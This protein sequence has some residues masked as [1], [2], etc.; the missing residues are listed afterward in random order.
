MIANGPDSL[1][2]AHAHE[3][4]IGGRWTRP[5]SDARLSLVNPAEGGTFGEVAEA[6][7]ADVAAAVKAARQAFDFGPWP[8]L[9]VSERASMLRAVSAALKRR[10]FAAAAA[11]TS[12]I[13]VPFWMSELIG[14]QII[15]T[16]DYY[17]DLIE[18]EPL[19]DTRASVAPGSSIALVVKEPVG[20]VAAIA[21]W[22]AP[23]AQM[24]LK[25]APALAAGCTVVAKPAPESPI[26]AFLLA[27][28][29]EEA[30]L[31]AGVFN[32]LPAGRE[33][34]DLLVRHEGI[35]KVS[36][37]G[38]TAVGTHIAQICAGRMARVTMEL[39]GKSA[40]VVLE[41]MDPAAAAAILAPVVTTMS[42]QVCSN[43]TRILT[44]RHRQ[45]AY[46]EALSAAMAATS[47]GDPHEPGVMMGP[48]A[49]Q[50]QRERVEGYISIGVAEGARLATGGGR[51]RGL[52][53]GFFFEPTVFDG[54]TND[55]VIAREEIF[56]PVAVIIPYDN[57]EDA[58]RLANASSFGLAGA[59]LTKDT[60][61]AYAIARRMRTGSI[62]QNGRAIDILIPFG[63]FKRSGMGRECG[64]EGLN[65][66]FELKSIFLPA[67]P[68]EI[69]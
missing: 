27:E 22:N 11:W 60:D 42:G 48:L 28:A 38:S 29:I 1:G 59:V 16:L 43:L 55:M 53:R 50:R 10:A 20:V 39:G 21:P 9:P 47:V 4:F 45:K 17:A 69:A 51:P 49:M 33:A 36:F 18:A 66:Y 35:D 15:N 14:P 13:G 26:E 41:D 64:P 67:K 40:A 8:T 24:L 62:T 32:L 61:K 31:P 7:P 19:V 58:V 46:V 54:V 23:L 2:L 25:V 34:S 52:D 65:A 37:T 6:G 56:G 3:L 30:G 68:R 57:E 5:S 12:Q 44:P 63:G